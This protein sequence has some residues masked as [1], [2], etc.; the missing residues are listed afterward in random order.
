MTSDV[1]TEFLK[2]MIHDNDYILKP[3]FTSLDVIDLFL[4]TNMSIVVVAFTS[5][6]LQ[7]NPSIAATLGEW[8]FGCYTEVAV[9]EG[10][11]T[12]VKLNRDQG[13]WSF[14]SR[15]LLLRGGR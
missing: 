4:D 7:W 13:Y 3:C 2:Q 9:V 10:F 11:Y 8:H 1:G 14:Y 6:G 12:G 5:L 15:W